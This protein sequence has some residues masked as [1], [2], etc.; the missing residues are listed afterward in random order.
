MSNQSF[1][2]W[3]GT[4]KNILCKETSSSYVA[5]MISR[6]VLTREDTASFKYKGILSSVFRMMLM[7]WAILPQWEFGWLANG[8]T[9]ATS[10][11]RWCGSTSIVI[12]TWSQHCYYHYLPKDRVQ[13]SSILLELFSRDEVGKRSL[14]VMEILFSIKYRHAPHF[15]SSKC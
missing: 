13:N 4:H 3:G 2:L 1:Q 15:I 7:S 9:H 12:I 14:H 5:R 8:K 6:V 11:N 10:C